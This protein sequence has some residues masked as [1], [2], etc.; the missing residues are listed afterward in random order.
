MEIIIIGWI[1]MII[2]SGIVG[3]QSRTMWGVVG[4]MLA[5]VGSALIN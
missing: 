5:L 2:G 4:L 3:W 1:I